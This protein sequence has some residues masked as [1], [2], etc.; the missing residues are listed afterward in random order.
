MHEGVLEAPYRE[1][2][3]FWRPELMSED[4]SEMAALMPFFIS[5][6]LLNALI[7]AG[8]YACYRSALDG[9]GWKKG[10]IFGLS[11][12]ILLAGLYSA[13]HFVF[14]MPA[15]IWFWWA[16]SGFVYLTLGGTVVGWITAKWAPEA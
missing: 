9:P 2:E 6:Q 4:Q 11:I 3:S 14:N 8:L 13:F 16:V 15:T 12:A 10:G 7:F 5:T 1:V